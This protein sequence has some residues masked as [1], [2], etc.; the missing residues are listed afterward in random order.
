MESIRQ[1]L[2]AGRKI[3]AMQAKSMGD[4]EVVEAPR[5]F[6]PP[7]AETDKLDAML[8][9]LVRDGHKK[10]LLDLD[11]ST[12]MTSRTIG[13]LVGVQ[14]NAFKNGAAIYLCNVDKHI[15]HLLLILWL[16]RVLNVLGTRAEALDFLGRLDLQLA[17]DRVQFRAARV[18]NL[19]TTLAYMWTNTGAAATVSH[20]ASGG[21]GRVMLRMRD[22]S[23]HEVFARPLEECGAFASAAGKPGA[24][25]IELDMTDY[26]GPLD[27]GIAKL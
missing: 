5:G 26:T 8:R 12:F 27:L 10:I 18:E 19:N 16:T 21:A 11:R 7:G 2:T 23:G 13:M 22:A 15:H 3:M 20:T 1:S 4:V 14:A 9:E 17:D 24:W 6:I 25:R